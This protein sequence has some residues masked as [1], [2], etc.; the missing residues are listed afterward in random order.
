MSTS[1]TQARPTADSVASTIKSVLSDRYPGSS[2]LG[3]YG[4]QIDRASATIAASDNPGEEFARQTRSAGVGY[5]LTSRDI[6]AVSAALNA[7]QGSEPD[8]DEVVPY[9][10]EAQVTALRSAAERNHAPSFRVEAILADSGLIEPTPE[11][12]PE[13]EEDEQ[14]EVSEKFAAKVRSVLKSLGLTHD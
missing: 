10:T 8:E 2:V 12:E 11:P 7:G 14:P 3:G 4:A 1:T 5:L 6:E 13:V 9:L